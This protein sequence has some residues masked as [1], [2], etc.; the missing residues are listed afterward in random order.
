MV[1]TKLIQ[2]NTADDDRLYTLIVPILNKMFPYKSE[3]TRKEI[4]KALIDHALDE[5]GR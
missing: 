5:M 3:W 4:I 2:I 1:K